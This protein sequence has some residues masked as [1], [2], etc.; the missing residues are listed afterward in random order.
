MVRCLQCLIETFFVSPILGCQECIVEGITIAGSGY[1]SVF[2][3][4]VYDPSVTP[5]YFRWVKVFTWKANGDGISPSQNGI[6]EDCFMRT[7]VRC[8]TVCIDLF[9]LLILSHQDDSS[10]V[11]GLAIRRT[12]Y[13]QD[14]NGSTLKFNHIGAEDLNRHPVIIEVG[15]HAT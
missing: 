14:G 12:V 8:V 10:Y 1:A 13:W 6:I 5:T 4:S 15:T 9:L 11:N 7:Q 3:D 2:L